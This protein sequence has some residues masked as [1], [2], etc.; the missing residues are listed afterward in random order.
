VGASSGGGLGKRGDDRGEV[1]G[2][3]AQVFAEHGAGDRAG[4]GFLAQPR[5]ADLE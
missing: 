5:L 4:G 3:E 1:R 2:G